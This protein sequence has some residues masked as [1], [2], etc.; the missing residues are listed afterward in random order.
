MLGGRRLPQTR[1]RRTVPDVLAGRAGGLWMP[2]SL[3]TRTVA[4]GLF[5]TTLVL[6]ACGMISPAA[7]TPTAAPVGRA[8]AG[9]GTGTGGP[10]GGRGTRPDGA[11]GPGQRQGAGQAQG[12]GQT[13]GQA[14]G[15]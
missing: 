12:T 4:L 14:Q 5:A 2:G 3:G 8:G 9:G 10:G 15:Q 7:P 1:R 6:T 11:A 13:D